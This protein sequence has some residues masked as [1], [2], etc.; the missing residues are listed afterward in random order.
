MYMSMGPGRT[1]IG[2]L[3]QLMDIIAVPLTIIF[4]RPWR[5]GL[6]PEG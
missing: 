3:R 4:E 1:H 6:V 2:V 5:S